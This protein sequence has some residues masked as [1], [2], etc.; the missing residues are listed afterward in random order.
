MK[1]VLN[2]TCDTDYLVV[3]DRVFATLQDADICTDA[4]HRKQDMSFLRTATAATFTGHVA[5]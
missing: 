5:V 2:K 3:A 1:T 4:I